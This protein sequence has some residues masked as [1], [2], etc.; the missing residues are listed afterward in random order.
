MNWLSGGRSAFR[1]TRQSESVRTHSSVAIPTKKEAGV[2]QEHLILLLGECD[3]HPVPHWSDSVLYLVLSV[4]L[5]GGYRFTGK[6]AGAFWSS[7]NSSESSGE[8][9]GKASQPASLFPR[10]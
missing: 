1:A 5:S 2:G 9:S 3:Q 6:H 4:T 7:F 10:P 8:I